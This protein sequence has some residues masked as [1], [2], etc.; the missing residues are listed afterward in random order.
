[1]T[2]LDLMVFSD[3]HTVEEKVV[4]A[5]QMK[6]MV[7]VMANLVAEVKKAMVMVICLVEKAMLMVQVV[8]VEM[9]VAR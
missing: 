5:L 8:V 4:E 1:M 2:Y 7:T 9:M 6:V 3:F